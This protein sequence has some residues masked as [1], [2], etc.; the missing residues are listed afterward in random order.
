M[1]ARRMLAVASAGL[2]WAATAGTVQSQSYPVRPIRVVVP[3]TAGG[4]TDLLAR[5]LGQRMSTSLGQPVV[6]E[7][8]PGGG[9][10]IGAEAVARAAPDGYTLLVSDSST[11]VINPH[12]YR[13]VP[14]D[15]I[16][17]FTPLAMIGS[18]SPVIAVNATVPVRTLS[19]LVAFSRARP[20]DMRYGS[21]GN[22]SYP[23]I[24]LEQ[25]KRLTGASILHVPY[26]GAAPA[27]A[28]L[29]A[30]HITMMLGNITTFDAL[31]GEGKLRLVATATPRR[32]A[33]HPELPT[34]SESGLPG[35][36]VSAWWGLL[37]PA[38]LPTD[39]IRKLN[40]AANQV[41]ALPDFRK[42]FLMANGMEPMLMSPEEFARFLQADLRQWEPMVRQSGATVD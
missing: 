40:S 32:L 18:N 16:R 24:A 36:E 39:V 23:H 20:E 2:L 7:N 1:S 37:G 6:I 11:F 22:G 15:A 29:V 31:A 41:L 30:G 8:R 21:M 5:T 3:A 38:A 4:L 10:M 42:S 33:S 28:D 27:V 26:K 9:Q 25:F 19:E 12:L 14:Y 35:F 13:K 17:D 34:A